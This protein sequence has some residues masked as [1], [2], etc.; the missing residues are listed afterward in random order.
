M[1]KINL[2]ESQ[3]RDFIK[4]SAMRVIKEMGENPGGVPGPM[5]GQD[6]MAKKIFNSIDFSQ[7]YLEDTD[8]DLLGWESTGDGWFEA[9]DWYTFEKDG[10]KFE[11]PIVWYK[12][13]GDDPN[14]DFQG[15]T[16]EIKYVSPEG[17]TG[18]FEIGG[19]MNENRV[20]KINENTIKKII[21]ESVKKVLKEM[22]GN[23]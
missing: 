7:E 10:W 6:D 13:R 4:E 16:S 14:W 23:K 9:F 2:T 17:Q 12:R 15:K 8:W 19:N 22:E 20:I 18:S 11:A 21:A 5:P 3:L 1:K